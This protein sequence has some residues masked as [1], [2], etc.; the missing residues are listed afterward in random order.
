VGDY[1]VDSRCVFERKTLLDFAASIIDGRLFSQARQLAALPGLVAIVLE[2]R[3][4]DLAPCQMRREALQGAVISLSLV[5]NIPILRSLAP[6]ETARLMVYAAHQLRRNNMDIVVRRGKRPKR[7]R[8]VQLHILQGLPGIG[9]HRAEQLLDSFG[10]VEAVMM[11]SP[12]ALQTIRG[13]GAKT[14]A[15]I[16]DALQEEPAPYGL[17]CP[18]YEI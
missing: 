8:I 18:E 6:A 9:P 5:F 1:E 4:E 16:R 14:A 3:A 17:T 12:E 7:K 15:A 10:C 13:I 2:G 11:A